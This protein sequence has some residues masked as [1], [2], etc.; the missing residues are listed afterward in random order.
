MSH[1][2]NLADPAFEPTDA[3]LTGLSARAFARVRADHDV[4]L[5]RLRAEIAAARERILRTVPKRSA[6]PRDP[7]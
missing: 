4:A 2:H 1:P 3:E 5:Q 6:P 7:R